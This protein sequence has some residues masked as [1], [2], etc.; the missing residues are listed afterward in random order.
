MLQERPHHPCGTD[1]G[2]AEMKTSEH[3]TALAMRTLLL[4]VLIGTGTA[5]VRNC[6]DMLQDIAHGPRSNAPP[7]VAT[8]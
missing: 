6:T 4:L 5:I 1:F 3:L 7:P 8:K 2:Q